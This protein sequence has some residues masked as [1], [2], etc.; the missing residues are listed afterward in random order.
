MQHKAEQNYHAKK[1]KALMTLFGDSIDESEL[2]HFLE[3][4]NGNLALVIEK[5]TSKLIN[6]D[7]KDSEEKEKS[8]EI[9]KESEKVE[10]KEENE[11]VE[12]IKEQNDVEG[13]QVFLDRI[14]EKVKNIHGY[15]NLLLLKENNLQWESNQIDTRTET[16]NKIGNARIDIDLLNVSFQEQSIIDYIDTNDKFDPTIKNE[17]KLKIIYELATQNLANNVE[18]RGDESKNHMLL[19][20]ISNLYREIT[21]NKIYYE[22]I[23]LQK[24][25]TKNDGNK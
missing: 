7:T 19:I 12:Q 15:E 17:E 24:C 1:M 9:E 14:C 6:L 3:E 10:K 21:K 13:L 18:N 4:N 8:K 22:K 5:L 2:E 25:L 11:K 23:P 16:N 20:F